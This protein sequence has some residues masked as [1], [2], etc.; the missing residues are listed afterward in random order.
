VITYLPNSRGSTPWPWPCGTRS[1]WGFVSICA[2]RRTMHPCYP[3]RLQLLETR[4][5]IYPRAYSPACDGTVFVPALACTLAG[6]RSPKIPRASSAFPPQFK[7]DKRKKS[8]PRSN[9]ISFGA[10]DRRTSEGKFAWHIVEALA[11]QL[12]GTPTAAR[13]LLI[14]STAIKALRCEILTRVIFDRSNANTTDDFPD[15]NLL[16]WMDGL[17]KDLVSLGL[18]NERGYRPLPATVAELLDRPRS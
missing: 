17:R 2:L 16:K 15:Y 8:S 4:Y 13:Q 1:A 3:K 5:C 9:R 6:N 18:D 10:L 14:Q 11:E 7:R 12:G